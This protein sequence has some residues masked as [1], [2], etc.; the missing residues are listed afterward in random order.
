MAA[1]NISD[2]DLAVDAQPARRLNET[3]PNVNIFVF[4]IQLLRELVLDIY[5]RV[6]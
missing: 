1:V 4:N 2:S 3:T 5:W 6:I